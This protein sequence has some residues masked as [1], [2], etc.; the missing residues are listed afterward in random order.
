MNRPRSC[1]FC[2]HF[3]RSE[4]LKGLP[5]GKSKQDECVDFERKYKDEYMEKRTG[6]N[7]KNK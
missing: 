2:I 7:Y 6:K 4:N 3:Q 5:C 1:E